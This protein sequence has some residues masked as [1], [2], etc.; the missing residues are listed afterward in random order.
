[1]TTTESTERTQY[2]QDH[3]TQW[4]VS[5]LTQKAYCQEQGLR[6]A[7][8]GYWVRKL[9]AATE[10][11]GTLSSGFVPVTAATSPSGLTLALPNGLEIRGIEADNLCLVQPL[12]GALG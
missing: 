9:R 10:E 12:L 1:M 5:G 2:W 11:V 4:Q 3:I 6:Y 8:F 7:T